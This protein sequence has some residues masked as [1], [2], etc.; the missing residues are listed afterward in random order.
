M[1]KTFTRYFNTILGL[2]L[3]LSGLFYADFGLG[4]KIIIIPVGVL[5]IIF[6]QIDFHSIKKLK[7]FKSFELER[8]IT[9]EEREVYLNVSRDEISSE[10]DEKAKP[11]LEKA[12]N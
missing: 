10:M 9:D 11:Y 3:L 6:G 12:E 7:F 1:N 5:F 8:H 2:C 4:L